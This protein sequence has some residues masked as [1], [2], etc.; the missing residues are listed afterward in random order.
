MTSR[1]FVFP[2]IICLLGIFISTSSAVVP[3]DYAQQP[4]VFETEHIRVSPENSSFLSY[5][6]RPEYIDSFERS[7][8]APWTTAGY[9]WAIRDTTDTYG[10]YSGE[11]RTALHP[12]Y[13]TTCKIFARPS[14]QSSEGKNP[15][16]PMIIPNVAIKNSLMRVVLCQHVAD[17][18]MCTA[19]IPVRPFCGQGC[20][21]YEPVTD[22]FTMY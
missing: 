10:V 21:R 5:P 17:G 4:R 15:R 18:L 19:D 2:V 9:L 16:F 13:F 7:T 22:N 12:S 8:I 1:K 14:L 20:P 6:W 3:E 11:R